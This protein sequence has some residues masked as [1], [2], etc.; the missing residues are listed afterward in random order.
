[1]N[2]HREE[3]MAYFL[4]RSLSY[5][6]DGCVDEYSVSSAFVQNPGESRQPRKDRSQFI[7]LFEAMAEEGEAIYNKEIEEIGSSASRKET[8]RV[9][10]TN[11]PRAATGCGPEVDDYNNRIE[12]FLKFMSSKG[13]VYRDTERKFYRSELRKS[14]SLKTNKTPPGTPGSRKKVVRFADAMGLDLNFV[15]NIANVDIPP[16]VPASALA[17]LRAGLEEDRRATGSSFL[18]AC[19]S[20]PGAGVDFKK[21]VLAQ[22]VCLE[23]AV[24][25]GVTITGVIRVA[26]I[27]FD[28]TVQVRYSTDRWT[29]FHDIDA[30]YVLNSCDGP[31]DR[32]SFSIV[33]PAVFDVGFRLE[34]AI[35]YY[36]ICNVFWDNN[37]GMNYAF[38]C[39]AKTVPTE[40]ENTWMSFL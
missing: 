32:F 33:A 8:K 4:P 15:R 34:F 9:C 35:A 12:A 17:D 3:D 18:T 21:K 1:M 40:A 16:K 31:T 19:F 29:T 27:A 37:C 23:N 26:N 5:V 39:F 36:T 14:S 11:A 7:R 38:E 6:Q 22:K 10:E 25:E 30:S 13:P 2:G 24:I 20:Q 28:K